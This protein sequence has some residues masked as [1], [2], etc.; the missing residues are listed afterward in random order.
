MKKRLE[1]LGIK[2]VNKHKRREWV[3]VLLIFIGAGLYAAKLWN[4]SE[5]TSWLTS[6]EGAKVAC[7]GTVGSDAK[8]ATE[9]ARRAAK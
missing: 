8:H 6:A 5:C 9:Q 3:V 2:Q 4:D 7:I 1:Y